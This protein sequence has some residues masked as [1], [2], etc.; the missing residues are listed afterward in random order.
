MNKNFDGEA[1]YLYDVRKYIE[2]GYTDAYTNWSEVLKDE[3]AIYVIRKKSD[4][5]ESYSLN[6]ITIK[7]EFKIPGTNIILEKGDI[8]EVLPKM[9]ESYKGVSIYFVANDDVKLYNFFNDYMLKNKGGLI[10]SV[11]LFSAIKNA[12]Y[13]MGVS[14]SLE[15][16]ILQNENGVV[17]FTSGKQNKDD[18][19]KAIED[20]AK[21][22][23]IT[24]KIAKIK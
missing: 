17:L 16:V 13:T 4:I 1:L 18:E 9:N 11:Y 19:I 7:E 12:C 21:K 14:D 3:K 8:I 2:G 10:Q 24:Y 6:T 20:I 23:G 5:K 22:L 15:P